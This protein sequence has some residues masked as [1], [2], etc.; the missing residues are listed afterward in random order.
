[1]KPARFEK[2]SYDQCGDVR[3]LYWTARPR[4]RKG[5]DTMSVIQQLNDPWKRWWDFLGEEGSWRQDAAK[6][7]RIHARLLRFTSA[8]WDQTAWV[9]AVLSALARG[10][11]LVE[12]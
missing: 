6:R 11:P 5:D 10:K 2:P 8:H 7:S 9:D 3:R 1:M 4:C 12:A